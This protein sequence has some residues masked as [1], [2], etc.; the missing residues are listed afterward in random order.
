M[1]TVAVDRSHT[2]IRQ[3]S[4]RGEQVTFERSAVHGG[5]HVARWIENFRTL[6][7]SRQQNAP[8]LKSN[9]AREQLVAGKFHLRPR[10]KSSGL[11]IEYLC[12]RICNLPPVFIRSAR[13]QHLAVRQQ[14][15]PLFVT[16]HAHGCSLRES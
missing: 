2:A 15:R 14:R 7:A 6:G 4:C 8:I 3:Q 12:A 1:A 10:R 16:R 9:D 5:K 11:W 13:D